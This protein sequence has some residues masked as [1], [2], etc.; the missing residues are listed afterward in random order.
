MQN[1]S[2]ASPP[3]RFSCSEKINGCLACGHTS[4]GSVNA[5]NDKLISSASAGYPLHRCVCLCT[6]AVSLPVFSVPVMTCVFVSILSR[7]MC[8]CCLLRACPFQSFRSRQVFSPFTVRPGDRVSS[9]AMLRRRQ[10]AGLW[11]FFAV[12]LRKEMIL[13]LL[14]EH[15]S[16]SG[17]ISSDTVRT[18]V[19]PAI[20]GLVFPV[21][22]NV[23]LVYKAFLRVFVL[24]RKYICLYLCM[25]LGLSV[26][27]TC[28]CR[29][30]V[31][32]VSSTCIYTALCV[33]VFICNSP[34]DP[35]SFL[36]RTAHW[37]PHI[38]LP[39]TFK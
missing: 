1:S 26:S 14:I 20:C 16:S 11:C 24:M 30:C 21:C 13:D 3:S 10:A 29:S 4:A 38:N 32:G 19:R 12:R 6:C 2:Q 8:W 15:L 9:P 17:L 36:N 37:I 34:A 25:Y 23:H 27:C 28:E 7:C 22:M 33:C 39:A 5:A 18:C 35:L 31:L